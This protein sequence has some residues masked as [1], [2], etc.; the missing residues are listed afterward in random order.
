MS[1][2]RWDAFEVSVDKWSA[3]GAVLIPKRFSSAWFAN[4]GATTLV[5]GAS[6]AIGQLNSRDRYRCHIGHANGTFPTRC[7]TKKRAYGD[8]AGPGISA[9]GLLDLAF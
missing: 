1:R 4:Y 3:R 7:C 6:F 5:Y 9:L 8:E 2:S